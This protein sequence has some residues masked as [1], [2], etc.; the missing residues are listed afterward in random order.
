MHNWT[1]EMKQSITTGKFKNVPIR[2]FE[3]RDMIE[4]L[5]HVVRVGYKMPY[6]QK[7]INR[8]LKQYEN[9]KWNEDGIPNNR[10]RKPFDYFKAYF[11]VKDLLPS[12]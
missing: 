8:K 10:H 11:G 1:I 5:R 3:G 2:L 9:V 4:N 6:L 7:A 12:S